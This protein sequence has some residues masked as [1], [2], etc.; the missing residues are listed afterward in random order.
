M[1]T[2]CHDIE[3]N[4]SAYLFDEMEKAEK[5]RIERH[6]RTC[7]ICRTELEQLRE[8]LGILRE[9][10]EAEP[11]A[12]ELSGERIQAL[13]RMAVAQVPSPVKNPSHS[14]TPTPSPTQ[15]GATSP[16]SARI[17]RLRRIGTWAVG[18][19]AA[20][21]MM[22][23]IY[24]GYQRARE[25]DFRRGI[26]E[27]LTK[28]DGAK[29]QWALE[30]NKK[31][32]DRPMVGD[33]EKQDG[34]GYLKAFPEPPKGGT[35]IIGAVGE[36][37]KYVNGKTE[38]TLAEVGTVVTAV[39]GGGG[40]DWRQVSDSAEKRTG[41]KKALQQRPMASAANPLKS[42][43]AQPSGYQYQINNLDNNPNAS[44]SYPGHSMTEVGAIVTAADRDGEETRKKDA[45]SAGK[46]LQSLS[47][48]GDLRDSAPPT[49]RDRGDYIVSEL[50]N[51][52]G[53][54]DFHFP[55]R[56]DLN[57]RRIAGAS[58]TI[59]SQEYTVQTGPQPSGMFFKNYGVNP[60][61]ET[62]TDRFS[63][64]AADVDR[65]SYTIA[66]DYLHRGLLPP[67]EA[68]RVE[69]IIAYF[70]DR[71]APPK[72]DAFAVYSEMAPSPFDKGFQLLRIG[73][74]GR[75]IPDALRKPLNLTFVI[76][77]SGSMQMENRLGLVK[78]MLQMLA[79]KMRPDDKIGF[80]TFADAGRELLAPTSARESS[81]I[82]SA[83]ST[84]SAG[85]STNVAEGLQIG[86]AMARRVFDPNAVNRVILFSD[87][88]ANTGLT[89]SDAILATLAASA[90]DNIYLTAVGVGMGNYHDELL[91]QLADKGNGHYVYIDTDQEAQKFMTKDLLGAIEVIAQ[92]VKIQVEFNPAMVKQYRL[93]G[94][95]KR[96]VAD[97]DFRN[98]AVD[99]GEIGA[100]HSVTALYE[101]EMNKGNEEDNAATVFV[102]YKQP[103]K[104]MAVKEIKGPIRLR[105]VSKTFETADDHFK[106]VAIAAEYAEIL[107]NSYW[108]RGKMMSEVGRLFDACFPGNPP[109]PEA[110][111]LRNLI[112]IADRLTQ[113]RSVAP[114]PPRP[115][116]RPAENPDAAPRVKMEE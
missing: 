75:E 83:I 85:G 10:F 109:N 13:R 99:A 87:G 88:V 93:L 94:F 45:Q 42:Q 18:L 52:M 53:P 60:F 57:G 43:P 15:N 66:R 59:P 23:P 25:R 39:E 33:L 11:V 74:K 35:Y 92:D 89:Q 103:D 111:D 40:G 84:L 28:I 95:E 5:E 44:S 1:N 64:F 27:T 30:N 48:I 8:T 80:A 51:G 6:V 58:E 4:L 37:P 54:N 69:E 16:R 61:V 63:T 114:I 96:D 104:E 67:F 7:E 106:L 62:R 26:E 19:A 101:L 113:S 46:K 55:N 97:K 20:T 82:Y 21:I 110:G 56:F 105:E 98:D 24:S 50:D 100:G 77:V 81:A 79:S 29:E 102:R 12:A 68:V 70:P 47:A 41:G 36:N 3:P 31:A 14:P 71:Y 115:P 17:I 73:L 22:I 116:Q 38:I 2:T 72:E 86:Y 76:D 32:T 112:E 34:S 108:A 65:A 78:R 107:R 91:Q 90:K 9:K 49:V